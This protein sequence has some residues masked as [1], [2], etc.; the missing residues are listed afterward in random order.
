MVFRDT[1]IH[2]V[3]VLCDVDGFSVLSLVNFSKFSS[4]LALYFVVG[5]SVLS[6]EKSVRRNFPD[7][8]KKLS[9]IDN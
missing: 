3:V 5:A 7:K 8:L 1:L 9:K 4:V 2:L 6:C